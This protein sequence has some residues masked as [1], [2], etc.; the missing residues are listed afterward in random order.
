MSSES[1]TKTSDQ[2]RANAAMPKLLL[3]SALS[4]QSLA[5][6]LAT[7]GIEPFTALDDDERRRLGR[8]FEAEHGPII[9]TDGSVS[10]DLSSEEYDLAASLFSSHHLVLQQ[11]ESRVTSHNNGTRVCYR[12]TNPNEVC[13]V[14]FHCAPEAG[15]GPESNIV[16]QGGLQQSPLIS[17]DIGEY[18]ADPNPPQR[19]RVHR[20]GNRRIVGMEIFS[21]T[22]AQ[23]TVRVHVCPLAV[24]GCSYQISDPHAEP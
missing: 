20:N 11:I 17:F 21:T 14:L 8:G 13:T 9:I 3:E 7:S 5:E 12:V 6:I 19:R 18:G 24:D 15:A 23:G 22:P 10:V 4:V 16:I 1:N 2:D